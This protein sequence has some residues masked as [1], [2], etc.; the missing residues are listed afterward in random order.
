MAQLE[1]VIYLHIMI[2]V[3]ASNQFKV[4]EKQ[5]NASTELWTKSGI[6]FD[7]TFLGSVAIASSGTPTKINIDKNGANTAGIKDFNDKKKTNIEIGQCKCLNNIV[8]SDHRNVNRITNPMM[9]FQ[10]F[11]SAKT[12]LAGIEN[13]GNDQKRA[14]KLH[15]PLRQ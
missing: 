11:S 13:G 4:L 5:I 12:V 9:R 15:A 1:T 8:E 2:I 10:S 14:V 3:S 6:Y 7:C